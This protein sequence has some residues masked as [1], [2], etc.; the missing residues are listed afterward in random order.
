MF[1]LHTHALCDMRLYYSPPDDYN[2]YKTYNF[3]VLNI[4]ERLRCVSKHFTFA[5][6]KEQKNPM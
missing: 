3:H 2:Y 5:N 6:D 4:Y 1:V